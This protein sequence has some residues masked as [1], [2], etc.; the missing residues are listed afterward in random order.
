AFGEKWKT[1][2]ERITG[3]VTGY[4]FDIQEEPRLTASEGRDVCIVANETSN[5][6][7]F[8]REVL[9]SARAGGGLV[10]VDAVSSMGGADHDISLG[11]IW[12]GS[13]QKCLGLPSGMG[14]MLLSPAALERAAEI[15]DHRFY[16]SLLFI[17]SQFDRF[18]TPYTPNILAVY[19][20]KRLLENLE[21]VSVI[22]ERVSRR[23]GG[24]YRFLE[25]FTGGDPLIRNPSVRSATVIAVNSREA[26]RVSDYLLRHGVIIG[27]GY[28]P[29]KGSTFRI[30]NFPAISDG[31]FEVLFDLLR[32]FAN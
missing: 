11:D 18:Q 9:K 31:D 7:A 1:Y 3:K 13:S 20:L 6:T 25:S 17:E 29:W 16:N 15:N 32:N 21:N 8:P 27:K 12:I 30:A 22:S 2:S 14:I 4:T 28:G 10:L 23:A 24:I 19:L 26:S 5:G